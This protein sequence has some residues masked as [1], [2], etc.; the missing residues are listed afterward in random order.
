M[1]SLHA[2]LVDRDHGL[3]MHN[4]IYVAECAIR[5]RL[6]ELE[7]QVAY[8]FAIGKQIRRPTDESAVAVING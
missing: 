1:R 5:G 6:P 4:Y 2:D 3:R 7:V 8:R